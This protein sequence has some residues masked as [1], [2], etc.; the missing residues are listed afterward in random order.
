MD[1]SR[2]PDNGGARR[3]IA[4]ALAAVAVASLVLAGQASAR[5]TAIRVVPTPKATVAQTTV[6]AVRAPA[7]RPNPAGGED[8][9]ANPRGRRWR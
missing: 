8:L 4:L 5:T 9:T 7:T 3:K 1:T 6:V 2:N